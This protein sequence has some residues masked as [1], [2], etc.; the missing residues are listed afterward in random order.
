MNGYTGTFKEVMIQKLSGPNRRSANSLSVETGV[1]QATLSRW[2]REY[3]TV[4]VG[5]LTNMSTKQRP[6]NWSAEKKYQTFMAYAVLDTDESRGRFLREN[7]LYSVDVDRWREEMIQA[8]N[9]KQRPRGKDPKDRR[10]TDLERE[11]RRK[12]K[13]L[14]EFAALLTLKK[15]AQQIW[16]A[17]EDEK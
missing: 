13:A 12:E 9:R 11:L 4:G 7:G 15:T 2:L 8:L 1:P 6:S 3:G 5:D 17:A 10:I 14:A 16:G